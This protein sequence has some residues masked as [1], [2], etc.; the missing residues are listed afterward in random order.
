M[1]LQQTEIELFVRSN[2]KRTLCYK[3]EALL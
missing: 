3:W 2:L 1:T